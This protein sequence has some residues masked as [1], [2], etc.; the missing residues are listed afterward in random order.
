MKKEELYQELEEATMDLLLC[1]LG[2]TMS[3]LKN[4]TNIVRIIEK[5]IEEAE[6][7]SRGELESQGYRYG[8]DF[9]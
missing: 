9:Y 6:L 3:M 8:Y 4:Q 1:L 5:E 2:G 7:P